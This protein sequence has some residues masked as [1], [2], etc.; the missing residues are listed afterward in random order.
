MTAYHERLVK[1]HYK[2][3]KIK[4]TDDTPKVE[5]KPKS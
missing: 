3:K 2:P 4:K 1:G 5:E